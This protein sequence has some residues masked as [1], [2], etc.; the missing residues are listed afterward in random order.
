MENAA[1]T[2]VMGP[3]NQIDESNKLALMARENKMAE[4]REG[5]RVTPQGI[6]TCVNVNNN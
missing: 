1:T 4:P 3:D 2:P 6:W 5:E